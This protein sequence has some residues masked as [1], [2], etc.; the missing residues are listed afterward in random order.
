MTTSSGSFT[1]Q[2]RARV[3]VKYMPKNESNLILNTKHLRI[4]GEGT[5]N[6]WLYVHAENKW[7]NCAK[8]DIFVRAVLGST[9]LAKYS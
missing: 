1:I 3:P 5:A 9:V 2:L 7:R 4:Q 6:P 8:C